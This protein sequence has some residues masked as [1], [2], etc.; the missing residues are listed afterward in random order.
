MKKYLQMIATFTL[1][2]MLLGACSPFLQSAGVETAQIIMTDG[3]GREITL[4]EP[5]QKIVSLAPSNT[6]I[7]FAIGAGGEVVGRDDFSNYPAEAG[8]IQTVGGSSGYSLEKIVELQ[9]D[10]VLAAEINSPEEVKAIEE[11]GLTVFYLSNP[12]ELDG[13]YENLRTV[14]GLTGHEEAAEELI[15]SLQ[16]RVQAVTESVADIES[17]PTIFYELDGSDPAKPWTSGQGTF[18]TLL[19]EMA[20]GNSIGAELDQPWTQISQEQLIVKN[21]EIILLGDAQWGTTPEMVAARPGWEGIQAVRENKI[22]PFNDDLVSRPGPR[23]VD[24]LEELVRV[25]HPEL[26]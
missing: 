22:I 2:G 7:L 1:I 18:I 20:G 13:M 21:P 9:P 17:R 23:L 19:I 12:V 25:L 11:L 4:A 15:V 16:S 5:A 26:Y 6:E 8:E 10:L 14:A 3:L 24:G